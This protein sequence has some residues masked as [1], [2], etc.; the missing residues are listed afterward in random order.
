MAAAVFG[1]SFSS[2]LSRSRLRSQF[3]FFGW[4]LNRSN[5][6]RRASWSAKIVSRT[7]FAVCSSTVSTSSCL[8]CF[9]A[10]PVVGSYERNLNSVL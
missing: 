8:L 1:L 9:R 6:C 4:I 2:L 5:S 7:M 10:C 3:G